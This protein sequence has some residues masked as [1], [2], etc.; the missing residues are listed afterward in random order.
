M[1]KFKKL[2]TVVFAFVFT[3]CL[4]GAMLVGCTPPDD[5]PTVQVTISSYNTARGT[6]TLDKE[7]YKEGDEV[8][9]TIAP[10]T[11]Y[12][13]QR[14]K[15]GGVDVTDEIVDGKYSFT[16]T[17]DVVVDVSF[18]KFDTYIVNIGEINELA[19]SVALS[20]ND[21]E[22]YVNE[23]VTVTVTANEGYAIDS[24]V[25]G[26]ADVTDELTDGVYS[27]VIT[28]NTNI[29]VE[30]VPTVT[31]TVSVFGLEGEAVYATATLSD[32]KSSYATGESTTLTIST[33]PGYLIDSVSINGVNKTSEFSVYG[34]SIDLVMTENMSVNVLF[35]IDD[36]TV[37][38]KVMADEFNVLLNRE[39]IMIVYFYADW[40]S[41]CVGTGPEMESYAALGTGAK[42]VKIDYGNPPAS[43]ADV[44]PEQNLFYIYSTQFASGQIIPLVVVFKD[45]QALAGM[46]SSVLPITCEDVIE[47]VEGIED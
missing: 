22:Y 1:N 47:L 6:V 35:S 7:S 8:V 12:E 29:D 9:I 18:K 28:A 14:F 44:T 38:Q 4:C 36:L 19:G 26:G 17:V 21:N 37:V 23:T 2:I 20:S 25:V 10:K 32:D 46:E 15:V 40:C 11:N 45:G 24:V 27:F 42:V 31:Y 5:R 41:A 3:A 33:K 34:G 13:I 43:A 16:A 30:F 39:G